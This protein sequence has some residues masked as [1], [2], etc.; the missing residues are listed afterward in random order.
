MGPTPSAERRDVRL[1]IIGAGL[2]GITV[3]LRLRATGLNDFVILDRGDEVGGVWREN[4]YPGVAV[5]TPSAIFSLSTH[6]N[7]RWSR[8]Y[9]L[10]QEI[11]EYTRDVVRSE[12]LGPHFRFGHEVLSASWDPDAHW[13]VI[14]TSQG[15]YR[16]RFLVSAAGLVTDASYPDVPGLSTFPGP[17]FHSS[18]WDHSVDLTGRRVA[19]VGTG[20]SAVQ[21]VPAIAPEVAQLHVL[22]RTA[23]WVVP[24][25]DRPR[26]EKTQKLRAAV[27][28]VMHA[29]RAYMSVLTEVFASARRF[30]VLRKFM[31]SVCL[32]HLARQVPDPELRAKLTPDFWYM[33]KRPLISN[34]YLPAFNRDNVTLHTGGLA[35]VEDNVVVA[36]DGTRIEADVLILNTGFQTGIALPIARR[37]RGIGQQLL[38]DYWDDDLRAYKGIC[39]PGFPNLFLTLGP[40][41]ASG[42]NSALVFVEAQARYIADAMRRFAGD[43]TAVVEVR[44]E[45]ERQW[46]SLVRRISAKTSYEL[47]G[48]RSYYQNRKGQNIIMWPGFTPSYRRYTRTFDP[49]AYRLTP[50]AELAPA[51][52]RTS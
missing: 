10:G 8:S 50:A 9:G 52:G 12:G 41:A 26:S 1:A 18:Q 30:Q 31:E 47:G 32:K 13:W 33:C 43:D 42:V 2:A 17:C 28:A 3:G 49:R 29:E 40:N 24:K 36:G 38:A 5:D 27:P 22:Q 23:A 7:P 37:I 34:D 39:V 44:E 20:A 14:E 25:K 19:V 4:T 16:A 11:L 45:A 35:A 21:F 51:A 6:P 15:T 46:T 48:C